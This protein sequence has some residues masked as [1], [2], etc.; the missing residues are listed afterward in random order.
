MG[1]NMEKK[2]NDFIVFCI[3]IFKVRS[4]LSGK[5]VYEIF[6]KYGVLKY[7]QEGYDMLHTQGDRWIMNDINEFLK[8]RGYNVKMS[9][10]KK[11]FNN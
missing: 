2:I 9:D 8:I 6:E 10:T 4:K 7:L 3:E 11:M 1:D 5:E